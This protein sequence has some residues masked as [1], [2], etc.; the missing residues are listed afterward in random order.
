MSWHCTVK[1][2]QVLRKGPLRTLPLDGEHGA[3]R[4]QEAAL[5][6]VGELGAGTDHPVPETRSVKS[7]ESGRQVLLEQNLQQQ[8]F[9]WQK[10]TSAFRT[11]RHRA[12]EQTLFPSHPQLWPRPRGQ[13]SKGGSSLGDYILSSCPFKSQGKH[14]SSPAFIPD[15]VLAS[16]VNTVAAGGY[17]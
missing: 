5:V 10:A 16:A 9:K 6:R 2:W 7:S 15:R 3:A 14:L 4:W 1:D 11:D 17:N 8:A 13:A 12:A